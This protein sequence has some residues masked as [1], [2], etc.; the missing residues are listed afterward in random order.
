MQQHVH[1]T[2]SLTVD[3][4][5]NHTQ[6]EIKFGGT[7]LLKHDFSYGCTS[8]DFDDGCAGNCPMLAPPRLNIPMHVPLVVPSIYVHWPVT[9]MAR[10]AGH[11]SIASPWNVWV[12]YRKSCLLWL[13]KKVIHS[14]VLRSNNMSTEEWEVI[15]LNRAESESSW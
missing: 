1:A 4:S 5:S 10:F 7:F 15:G 6:S 3:Q 12:D 9:Q 2:T 14:A 11:C 13:I 8:S